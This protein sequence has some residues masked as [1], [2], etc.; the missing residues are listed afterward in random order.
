[1]NAYFEKID[2]LFEEWEALKPDSPAASF[3]HFASFF[4][5]NC[6]AWLLSMREI[7]EPSIGREG[8]AAGIEAAVKDSEIIE[9]R[10]VG[11]A[12]SGNKVFIESLS[13]LSVHGQKMDS[14]PET[15]VITF[16]EE[17]LIAD[18]KIYSC[19]SPLVFLIQKATGK[20]PY[21]KEE[22]CHPPFAA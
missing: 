3:E 9:R 22:M 20:G 6:H 15:A 7:N 14:F 21:S 12:G 19:R 16:D 8:V 18:F 1:M 2:S 10:V 5:T 11:R 13:K 4:S 17:G